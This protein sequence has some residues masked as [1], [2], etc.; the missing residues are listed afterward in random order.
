MTP[1]QR[2]GVP[3]TL[4]EAALLAY[5]YL[6]HRTSVAFHHP[7]ERSLTAGHSLL[8]HPLA[9]RLDPPQNPICLLGHR[10]AVVGVLLLVGRAYVWA[11]H[12]RR[13]FPA[14]AWLGLYALGLGVALMLNLNA[15]LYLLPSVLL[16]L[17]L[18]QRCV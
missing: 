18:W 7:W 1:V 3:V 14:A 11:V 9:H 15:F 4:L 10:A 5:L 17:W 8:R 6:V 2:L 16:E 12:G 13:I